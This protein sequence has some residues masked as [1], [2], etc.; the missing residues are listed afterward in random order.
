MH[1]R[2]EANLLQPPPGHHHLHIF[3]AA[4]A[5]NTNTNANNNTT[6]NS[7]SNPTAVETDPDPGHAVPWRLRKRTPLY[8][9]GFWA[10]VA[11]A[12]AL[13]IS[14]PRTSLWNVSLD[15]THTSI[16]WGKL[17]VGLLIAALVLLT[18]AVVT[19][20]DPGYLDVDVAMQ[21]GEEQAMRVREATP[22]ISR[23][24][25][26]HKKKRRAGVLDSS[27]SDGESGGEDHEND[28]DDDRGSVSA[29]A[30]SSSE[31]EE[32]EELAIS[33]PLPIRRIVSASSALAKSAP[34]PAPTTTRRRRYNPTTSTGN[35]TLPTSP[36]RPPGTLS[37]KS[38]AKGSGADLAGEAPLDNHNTNDNAGDNNDDDD[39]DHDNDHDDDASAGETE[40]TP[41][42]PAAV[43]DQPPPPDAVLPVRAKY[44]RFSRKVVPTFD[45][46][47]S[48]LN[49]TIGERNRARFWAFLVATTVGCFFCL[50]ITRSGIHDAPL[51]KWLDL[52]LH[53]FAATVVFF[54]LALVML[55]F[56]VFHTF[57]MMANMTTNEFLRSEN[58]SYLIHTRDFDLPFSM[59]L[60]SNIRFF[61]R[62]DAIV[63][64]VLRRAVGI[65][66]PWRPHTWVKP[67][68]RVLRLDRDS[69]DVCLN[70]WENKYY[71]CC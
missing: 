6:A 63:D 32:D 64:D 15:G 13:T 58:V 38:R 56:S 69:H 57:L 60:S 47:C 41:M 10:A 31:E 12:A 2:R 1:R 61:F 51:G 27:G 43:A 66:T 40:T 33:R 3:A 42:A 35:A 19:G 21:L 67:D 37:K 20:S 28:K 53:A 65:P 16:R 48:V 17:I 8:R 39:H 52:N 24:H 44:C 49:T 45:H 25:R 70:P 68:A 36:T 7:S 34:S 59:G 62:S 71:S 4:A 29:S 9:R 11:A 26:N 23:R 30:A 22:R 18:H 50:A 55:V 5:T 46:H 14:T 54:V